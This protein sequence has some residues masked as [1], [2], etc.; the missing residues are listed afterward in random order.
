MRV[1]GEGMVLTCAVGVSA[2]HFGNGVG[3][4]VGGVGVDRRRPHGRRRGRVD[5]GRD[6]VERVPLAGR[7][8]HAHICHS[9]CTDTRHTLGIET[10]RHRASFS[11]ARSQFDFKWLII[12]KRRC[13]R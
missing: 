5:H 10:S 4:S 6:A 11:L 7:L 9:H 13:F 1:C 2:D 12:V 3:V 8:H